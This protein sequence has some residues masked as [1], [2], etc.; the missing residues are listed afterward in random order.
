MVYECAL[1]HIIVT[2]NLELQG[3]L[4][5]FCLVCLVSTENLS[6]NIDI[7]KFT[8]FKLHIRAGD[9]L[10]TVKMFEKPVVCVCR[11]S[12]LFIWDGSY[13]ELMNR[14]S[15]KEGMLENQEWNG[16]EPEVIVVQYGRGCWTR[17]QKFALIRTVRFCVRTLISCSV[18]ATKTGQAPTESHVKRIKLLR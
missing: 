9:H 18:T 16:T 12:R 13:Q 2:S 4:C 1:L 7:Y 5:F 3:N 15:E 17:S 10:T 11:F 8:A 14:H 6:I